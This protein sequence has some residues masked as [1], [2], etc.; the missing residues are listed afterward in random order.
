VTEFHAELDDIKGGRRQPAAKLI[1]AATMTSIM[2]AI[3]AR[4]AQQTDGR[5]S[6]AG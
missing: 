5:T 1:K 4:R 6:S 3:S 2:V